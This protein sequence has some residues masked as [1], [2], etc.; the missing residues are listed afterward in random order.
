MIM[1]MDLNVR[2]FTSERGLKAHSTKSYQV[3][4]NGFAVVVGG[5]SLTN[6]I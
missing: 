1:Y 5:V 6:S 3:D 4:C 2:R